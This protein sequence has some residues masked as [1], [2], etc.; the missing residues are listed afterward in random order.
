MRIPPYGGT[1]VNRVASKEEQQQLLDELSKA[2]S[3][4]LNERH[5][6]DLYLLAVGAY[7]P[8]QGFMNSEVYRSVVET[9]HLPN[10]LPWTIPV[11]LAVHREEADKIRVRQKALLKDSSGLAI[12]VLVVEEKFPIDKRKELLAIYRTED[13][14]HPGVTKIFEMG[15]VLLAGEVTS[16]CDA[17]VSEFPDHERKPAETRAIFDQLRWNTIAA[18]QTRN[19]VHRAHEYLHKCA[20]EIIDGLMLHPLVGETVATDVPAALRMECYGVL[21][22][23]YYP[24]NRVLLSV[25]PAAM[26]YAGPRE[27]I[28]HAIIRRNYG[29]THFIVGRDHAGVGQYYGSYDAQEIFREVDGDKLGIVP[30]FFDNAFF[31]R[32]CDQMATS[33]TCPHGEGDRISLSG[34]KLREMLRRG[35]V[36]PP[37][38]TRPEVAEILL[39]AAKRN[40]L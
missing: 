14:N 2:P 24:Q 37:E 1:L 7:S 17:P 31:C 15:D 6:S 30:L 19:P 5:R 38:F 27:A 32:R 28:F 25:L 10:G 33:K 21:L 18:F 36:P 12:G 29:C 8:L 34:T 39:R 40:L 3:I 26:R 35:E 4:V 13:T 23:A 11:T 22:K 9:M 20:L 16:L